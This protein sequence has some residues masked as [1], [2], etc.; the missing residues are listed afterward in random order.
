MQINSGDRVKDC[1][2]RLKKDAMR[3]EVVAIIFLILGGGA[4]PILIFK[5]GEVSPF[6]ILFVG[7]CLLVSLL[8]AF[9]CH[10]L[11][12]ILRIGFSLEIPPY[13]AKIKFVKFFVSDRL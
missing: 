12:M 8:F 6:F 5:V 3:A 11:R 13:C 1:V 10:Y 9:A 7:L 4:V 2:L